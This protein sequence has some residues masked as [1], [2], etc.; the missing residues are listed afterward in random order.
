MTVRGCAFKRIDGEKT[1]LRMEV[2]AFSV[3]PAA[4]IFCYIISI[5][6]IVCLPGTPWR[7][8]TMISKAAFDGISIPIRASIGPEIEV[9]ATVDPR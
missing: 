8:R 4:K 2:R 5:L 1:D 9:K 3:T 6:R 7:G